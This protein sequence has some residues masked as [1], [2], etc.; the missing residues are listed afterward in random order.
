MTPAH[1]IDQAPRRSTEATGGDT[2]RPAG[3][4]A[5]LPLGCLCVALF[6]LSADL[7]HID[8]SGNRVKFGY[9]LIACLWVFDPRGMLG[10]VRRALAHVPKIAY[11]IALPLAIAVATS[12]DPA[13]SVLWVLWLG[14]DVFT[15]LTIHA[16][17]T[18]QRV[19]PQQVRR[20][21]T[22]SLALIAA[23][24]FTQYV[25][26]YF[27]HRVVFAPQL[28]FGVY[29]LNGLA[30]WPHF[31]NIFAFLLVP[32]VV[33]APRLDAFTNGML[34]CLVFV[35]V[36]STAK[37]GWVLAVALALLLLAFDRRALVRN[38]LL[39][40]VPLAM[41]ALL[42]PSPAL[43]ATAPVVSSTAKVARFAADLD[44][45]DRSTSGTDRMLIN[46]MGL[47]VWQKHPWFGVGPKAYRHYVWSR[48]DAELPGINKL[49]GNRNVN[50]K[51]ENIWI[52]FLA[53]NGALF[54]L[55]FA[56]VVAWALW[57]PGWRFANPLHLGAWIALVM[58][59]TVSGQVSQN[60]LLTMVYAVFGIY[61][62]ARGL[63]ADDRRA[64]TRAASAFNRDAAQ[65]KPIT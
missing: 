52:E 28:H 59:F 38:Y 29:R 14:F 48:F 49:D 35:L 27:I 10:V 15:A 33:V 64:A 26:I 16:F 21:I 31:L 11:L 45:T 2:H 55:M 41:V 3:F 53:E 56:V 25:S 58:Y 57:V 23:G 17:L 60:G 7:L 9:F 6:L 19:S 44:I 39:L 13:S 43:Q 12:A 32:M 40:L 5:W 34:V 65:A 18:V 8:V 61:F 50:A 22:A 54:T 42:L 46:A 37:T 1:D 30:G 24:A 51:N 47:E 36:Q 62:Y 20:V 4:V 63:P